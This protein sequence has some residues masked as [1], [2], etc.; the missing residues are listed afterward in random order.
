MGAGT[1]DPMEDM[2]FLTDKYGSEN[3]YIGTLYKKL[4][5]AKV[6]YST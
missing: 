3:Y 5:N 1:K 4:P 2:V 6:I